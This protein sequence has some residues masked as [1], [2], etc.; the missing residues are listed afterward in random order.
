MLLLPVW[1]IVVP[2]TPARVTFDRGVIDDD[3]D[4]VSPDSRTR[5]PPRC[6]MARIAALIAVASVAGLPVGVSWVVPPS[7]VIA[8]GPAVEV[9]AT[10]PWRLSAAR[11]LASAV[12]SE[13]F[14]AML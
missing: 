2:G 12:P 9:S 10:R 11:R 13:R 6:V 3:T 5:P 7:T 1:V 4:Q 14:P 8:P